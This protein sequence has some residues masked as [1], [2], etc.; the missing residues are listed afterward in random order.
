MFT[1]LVETTSLVPFQILLMLQLLLKT[2]FYYLFLLIR[3]RFPI[4]FIYIEYQ[5]GDLC[6][7]HFF[8]K[9]IFKLMSLIHLVV[10]TVCVYQVRLIQLTLKL[11]GYFAKHPPPP[12]K[13]FETANN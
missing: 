11:A 8:F 2:S 12:P 13:N 9:F 6:L 10:L 3:N 1:A 5:N 7:R 4:E